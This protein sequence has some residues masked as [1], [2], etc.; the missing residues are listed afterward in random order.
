MSMLTGKTAII[1]GAAGGI[2]RQTA[3]RFLA[4]GARVVLVDHDTDALKSA[5]DVLAEQGEALAVTADV[6]QEAAV[7][8]YV[9]TTLEAYGRIDV[10]FNNAAVVGR[11]APLVEQTAEDLEHLFA[12]NVRG[13]FLGLKHVLPVMRTQG[14][15]SIINTSSIAGLKGSPGMGLYSASKHAVVGLTKTA[16][17]EHA[18]DNIR[19]NSIHPAATETDMMRTIE[20]GRNPD[21]EADAQAFFR[22]SIPLGRYATPDDVARLAVFLASEA[23]AFISGSQYRIDGGM[24]AL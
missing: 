6:T 4:E 8:N 15:G 22:R 10:F 16:A 13:V 23:S 11:I 14:S 9:K 1:T 17:L 24:A 5:H 3:T 19:I 2:G 12:V 20:S 7:Q 21:H 18:K